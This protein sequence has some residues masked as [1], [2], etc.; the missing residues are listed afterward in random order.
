MESANFRVKH[1]VHNDA[2]GVDMHVQAAESWTTVP[3]AAV[4]HDVLVDEENA[5]YAYAQNV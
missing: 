1:L 4:L 2:D 5:A 3:A